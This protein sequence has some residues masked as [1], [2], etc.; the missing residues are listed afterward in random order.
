M[1]SPAHKWSEKLCQATFLCDVR[2]GASFPTDSLETTF[3]AICLHLLPSLRNTRWSITEASAK[4][5]FAA[6]YKVARLRFCFQET[7]GCKQTWTLNWK[8][9]RWDR[10][11]PHLTS[12]QIPFRTRCQVFKRFPFSAFATNALRTSDFVPKLSV[13]SGQRFDF[14][15]RF[16][17]WEFICR[18]WESHGFD[19]DGMLSSTTWHH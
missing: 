13:A 9:S 7:K 14:C 17:R 4:I 11:W 6:G 16:E 12:S 3:A 18:H 8:P 15:S 19:S 2:K 10:K 5:D 1:S